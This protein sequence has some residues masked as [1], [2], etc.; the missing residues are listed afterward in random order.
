M[1]VVEQPRTGGLVARVLGMI[2]KPAAEWDV[3]DGEAATIQGLFTGYACILAAIP[4]IMAILLGLVLASALSFVRFVLPFGHLL[5][6]T[7]VIGGA[8]INYV[9]GLVSAFVFGFIVDALA[10]SFD[11]QRS[12]IQGMKL[13]VYTPTVVWVSTV[14]LIIPVLGALVVLAAAIY[15][16]Y[17]FWIG[18][19]KLMKVPAEKAAGFNIVLIVAG[20]VAGVIVGAVFG[21]LKGM[22]FLGSLMGGGLF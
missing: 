14:A 12:Q 9:A 18:A 7:A 1:S 4:A 13:A 8:V 21:A 10:P 20:L 3:I 15:C 11:G 19:P 17:T 2:T 6:P 22:L 16:L 5:A